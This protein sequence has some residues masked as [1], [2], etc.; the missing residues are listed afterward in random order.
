MCRYA[1]KMGYQKMVVYHED[2][3][4]G[5]NLAN[6]YENAAKGMRITIV[7]RVSGLSNEQALKRA[8]AKWQALD[9]EGIFLGLN[10]PEGAEVIKNF[11][12]IDP[13]TPI[14]TGD[15]LDVANLLQ[16]L[17]ANA[18]GMVIATSYNPNEASPVLAEFQKRY[19]QKYQKEP[20]IWAIQGYDSLRL[21]AYLIE[22]TKSVSPRVLA[23][24]LRSM[25][26]WDSCFGKITF[27]SSGEVKG[28]KIYQKK[29]VQGQFQYI[30]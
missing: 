6:A 26:P 2:S 19:R 10:M 20:D 11:R 16:G 14:L 3:S 18:E 28:R 22:E 7:D 24:K 29:V 27:N 25:E 12:K 9:Y 21:L 5:E 30:N 8:H 4:Y 13:Q 1:L 23:E 17:A 15:G